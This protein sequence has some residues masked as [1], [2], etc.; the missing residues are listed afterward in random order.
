MITVFSDNKE[1]PVN[2][3]EFSDGGLT[4]KLD[5][6]PDGPR[7]ISINV[8][9]CTPVKEIREEVGMAVSCIENFYGGHLVEQEFSAILN[10]PY[11]GYA[12]ADRVFEEGNP[13]PLFDFVS[14]IE[15]QGFDEVHTCDIHNELPVRQILGDVLH[16]KQQLS[17]F[18]ESIAFDFDEY[19]DFV[20]APDKGAVE[21]AQTI[22][23][24]LETDIVFA[25]K[26]RC[27]KT[28]SIIA[29]EIPKVDLVGAKVLIPDDIFD[30]GGTFI[31][32]AKALKDAGAVQV[33]LY[34]S[35]MIGAK[36]LKC[37][38]G[39]IDNIYCYQTVGNFVNKQNVTDFNIGNYVK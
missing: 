37:L 38:T 8:D 23:S 16:V 20:V 24:H 10:M 17:C 28:G 11:L 34:V 6:L 13:S 30:A 36:G 35:H 25:G 27:I 2:K 7:Y 22:A 19:Y 1:I 4:F 3:V 26:K 39:V 18:R 33:D 5:E 14:W 15:Q 29:I 12:R 32:L 9:P 21:K 31:G